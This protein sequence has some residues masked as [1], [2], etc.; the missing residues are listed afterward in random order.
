[1]VR[2]VPGIPLVEEEELTLEDAQLVLEVEEGA[3]LQVAELAEGQGV[4]A[5]RHPAGEAG[6][7]IRGGGVWRC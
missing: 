5:R 1:M 4:V 2:M 6:V 3:G 7:A